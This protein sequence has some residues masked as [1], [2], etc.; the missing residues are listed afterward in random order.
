MLCDHFTNG[1]W[2]GAKYQDQMGGLKQ[3]Q[4]I[5]LFAQKKK[6]K[7]TKLIKKH[8]AYP[9]GMNDKV[10]HE[11]TTNKNKLIGLSFQYLPVNIFQHMKINILKLM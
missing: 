5:N 11:T 2:K 7:E 3:E 6:A 4:R 10:G 8:T 1:I 9:Y